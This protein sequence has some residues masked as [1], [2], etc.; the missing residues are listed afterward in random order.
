M[1]RNSEDLGTLK[2]VRGAIRD[3]TVIIAIFVIIEHRKSK[4][5]K[6]SSQPILI[7]YIYRNHYDRHLSSHSKSTPFVCPLCGFK[8]SRKDNLKQHVEKRHCSGSTTIKQIE[9]LYR[10]MY[11]EIPA[12]VSGPITDDK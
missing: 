11:N 12:I 9:H 7:F 2:F 3:S 10:D 1:G 8:C 5:Q 6:L 4:I